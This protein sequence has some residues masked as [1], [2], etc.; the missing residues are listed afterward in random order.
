MPKLTAALE[1]LVLLSCLAFGVAGVTL[2]VIFA[3]R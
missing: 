1:L 3:T 2:S